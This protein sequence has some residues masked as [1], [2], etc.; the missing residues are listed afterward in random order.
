MPV[1][2]NSFGNYGSL[3]IDLRLYGPYLI[4]R[5]SVFENNVSRYSVVINTVSDCEISSLHY[6]TVHLV[7]FF[8][9]FFTCSFRSDSDSV[10]SVTVYESQA[11]R[12][13]CAAKILYFILIYDVQSN[14]LVVSI[15]HPSIHKKTHI[16][17]FRSSVNDRLCR[18]DASEGASFEVQWSQGNKFLLT[19]SKKFKF[20]NRIP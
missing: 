2:C 5:S 6:Y 12:S 4:V 16:S 3:P 10:Q 20:I 17:M 19:K 9:E 8:L 18:F 7:R 13:T 11:V 14:C 1:T 15:L